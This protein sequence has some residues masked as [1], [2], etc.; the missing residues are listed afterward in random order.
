MHETDAT[1]MTSSRSRQRSCRG[2]AHAVDLF[3]HRGFFFDVGV[4]A[5]HVGFGLIIV[6]VRHEILNGVV[7][8][9]TFEFAVKLRRERLV[10][11]EDEGGALR[12]FDDVR[13]REGLARARDAEQHLRTLLL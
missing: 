6:V 8:E 11:R 12:C 2:V 7:G 3:V 13:H 9:K 4:G 1:M 5:R 10:G